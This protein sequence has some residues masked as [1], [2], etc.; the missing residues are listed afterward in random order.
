M[1][2]TWVVVWLW[3]TDVPS[4]LA[5]APFIR[6]VKML[7]SVAIRHDLCNFRQNATDMGCGVVVVSGRSNHEHSGIFH[8]Q[9]RNASI[10]SISTRV[11]QVSTQRNKK[12]LLQS[13]RTTPQ[14]NRAQELAHLATVACR[15]SPQRFPIKI[16]L[17]ISPLIY[18]TFQSI[19][20][21]HSISRH[22][23]YC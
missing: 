14:I 17:I 20:H 1:R 21:S 12:H 15:Y 8:L 10:G 9:C 23:Y 19:H 11:M 3:C 2:Q 4:M 16:G 13:C 18:R 5:R 7:P 22:K 6:H